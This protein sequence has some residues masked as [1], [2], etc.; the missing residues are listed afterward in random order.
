MVK[1]DALFV[2]AE[3]AEDEKNTQKIQLRISPIV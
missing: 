1:I 2:M 3:L